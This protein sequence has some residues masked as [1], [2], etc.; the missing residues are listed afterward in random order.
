MP[1]KIKFEEL[2]ESNLKL[3]NNFYDLSKTDLNNRFEKNKI[4]IICPKHGKF[5]MP[6]YDF[7][8]GKGCPI[9][10]KEKMAKTQSYTNKDFIKKANEVHDNFYNYEKCNY[11]KAH[12]KVVIICPIHGDFEQLA[13]S[14]LQG[15]KCPKCALESIKKKISSNTMDF[16][17]KA[18]QINNDP[19]IDF[20]Q[21][22]YKNN[23]TKVC[24]IC[25][26][27]DLNGIEHGQFW[28]KPN[29]LLQGEG[30]PICNSSHLEKEVK[31]ALDN[32]DID[33]IFQYRE[34][35]IKPL[36]LDF[37]IPSK[38]I[39]IECQGRQHYQSILYFGGI[40]GFAQLKERDNKKQ[41]IC[42][43]NNVKL[44]YFTHFKNVNE[45]EIT[46]KDIDKLIKKI[47]AQ[48]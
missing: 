22:N 2:I 29:N 24:I 19:L 5:F 35:W 8:H 42:K 41:Y 37:F 1:R 44:L 47:K 15:A 28:M 12:N 10:G 34:S 3:H 4:E 46:F 26:H 18:K 30:C 36:T 14:H 13:Y 21:V 40:H 43:E 38:K 11:T 32:N 48:G 9:C 17:Q 20:S 23:K 31:A 16:I 6:P 25:H 7:I 45:D 33:Y 27:K 39:A